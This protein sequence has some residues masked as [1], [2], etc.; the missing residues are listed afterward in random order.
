MAEA[1]AEDPTVVD[2]GNTEPSGYADAW[3]LYDEVL[4][5]PRR[6]APWIAFKQMRTGMNVAGRLWR[7]RERLRREYE[8]IHGVDPERW[9]ER[10]PDVVLQSTHWIAHPACLGCS[11]LDRDGID[12]RSVS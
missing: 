7:E 4:F 3:G 1:G 2:D 6:V 9:P 12:T 5:R 8:A 11:W 10:H